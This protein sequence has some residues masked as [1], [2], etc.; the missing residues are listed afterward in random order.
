MNKF[1]FF[2]L[3]S[4]L[5][6][7]FSVSLADEIQLRVGAWNIAWL[8]DG[9]N[10][11]RPRTEK[12]IEILQDYI[13]RTDVDVVAL[14]EIENEEAA[15]LIFREDEWEVFLS[16]RDASQRT[17]FAVRKSFS[18]RVNIQQQ[19]DYEALQT[20]QGLRYGTDIN[21]IYPD[22]TMI[23]LLSIHLKSGCFDQP[24]L[25]S[26]SV[27]GSR[28]DSCL[29]LGRQIMPLQE[30]IIQREEENV[31]FVIAGD[32]NRRII[33]DEDAFWGKLTG[34]IENN[35]LDI[36][37][38]YDRKSVCWGGRYPLPID[39]IIIGGKLDEVG[40]SFKE[41]KY[42]ESHE[43]AGLS[44][45]CLISVKV[46]IPVANSTPT[47]ESTEDKNSYLPTESYSL[48]A[49]AT[50]PTEN[51]NSFQFAGVTFL[52]EALKIRALVNEAKDTGEVKKILLE[53][54]DELTKQ[55]NDQERMLNINFMELKDELKTYTRDQV[56]EMKN[57]IFSILFIIG[58][59]IYG[60]FRIF[61][62]F[63]PQS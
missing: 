10:D 33:E 34:G 4:S 12:D 30:W 19:G 52:D 9:D 59:V 25:S 31:P 21:I 8:G 2:C 42:N 7:T 23:R 53:I 48:I 44:D 22:N 17:G 45:H 28:G 54:M 41:L 11:I 27:E 57:E 3:V 18:D 49:Y 63:Y 15:L 1:S 26:N 43:I 16:N 61:K 47:I 20:S 24:D 32:W 40:S 35:N 29:K 46:K 56:K 58:A 36:T 51:D 50:K 39:H 62:F 14:Q 5:M 13:D 6:L 55:K 60:S 38:G 37:G